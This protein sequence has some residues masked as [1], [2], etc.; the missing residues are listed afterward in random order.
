V[1]GLPW[2]WPVGLLVLGV[3]FIVIP[4]LWAREFKRLFRY[5]GLSA[6]CI[7]GSMAASS[8][9]LAAMFVGCFVLMGGMLGVFCLAEWWYHK[10][11]PVFDT[12]P[13]WTFTDGD[14]YARDLYIA[15]FES[16]FIIGMMYEMKAD[17]TEAQQWTRW[18]DR[19]DTYQEAEKALRLRA[20]SYGLTEETPLRDG[21]RPP[22]RR[23]AR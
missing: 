14:G 23:M 9:E 21:R 18:K 16:R 5:L 17:G 12:E 6:M 20:A 13:A 7:V 10:R 3:A 11:F 4:L 1:S 2:I 8:L 22:V 15:E 19:F